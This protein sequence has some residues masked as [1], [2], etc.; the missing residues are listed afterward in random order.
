M[1]KLNP[2]HLWSRRFEVSSPNRLACLRTADLHRHTLL[3]LNGKVVIET[4]DTVKLGFRDREAASEGV[5]ALGRYTAECDLYAMETGKQSALY[6]GKLICPLLN[7]CIQ[8][9]VDTR[10]HFG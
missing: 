2:Q 9:F 1:T 6:S 7:A 5:E 10:R 3:R 8:N 4:Y